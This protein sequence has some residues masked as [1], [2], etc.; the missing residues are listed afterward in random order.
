MTLTSLFIILSFLTERIVDCITHY[1]R[2]NPAGEIQGFREKTLL[3]YLST[4]IAF[5]PRP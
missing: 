3:E 4:A 1:P 5:T 2:R